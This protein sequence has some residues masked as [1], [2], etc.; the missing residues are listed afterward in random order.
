MWSGNANI[1]T[2]IYYLKLES[3]VVRLQRCHVDRLL[4]LAAG[5]SISVRVSGRTHM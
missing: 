1:Y 5:E 4:A 2:T 3:H